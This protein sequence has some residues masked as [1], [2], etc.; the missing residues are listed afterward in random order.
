MAELKASV[1]LDLVDRISRPVQRIQRR[2]GRLAQSAGLQR[3]RRSAAAVGEGFSNV[4][5]TAGRL[6]RRLAL[7][8]GAAA[9][10]VWGFERLVSG[11]TDVGDR[12]GKLSERLGIN[13]QTLQEWQYGARLSGI[14]TQ[15]FNMALQRFSRRIGEA[16]HGT[17][18]AQV[19]V[20]YL[21]VSLRDAE[22]NIRSTEELLPEF[23]DALAGVENEQTRLALAMKLFDSEGVAMLQMLNGGSEALREFAR[24]AHRSGVVLTD[25]LIAQ[26]EDYTDSMTNFRQSLFGIRVAIVSRVIPAVTDWI[27]RMTELL[28]T[29]REALSKR[30]TEGLKR[31]WEGLKS[32]GEMLV[33]TKDLLGGWGRVAMLVG[34]VLLAPLVAPVF[35]LAAAIL[36]MGAALLAIGAPAAIAIGAIVAI[37]GAVY[38][39]YRYWDNIAG[40]FSERFD[41]VTRA[42]EQDLVL[43][44]LTTLREFNPVLLVYEAVN[45]IIRYLTGVDL[46][47][48][49]GRSVER[50]IEGAVAGLVRAQEAIAPFARRLIHGIVEVLSPTA[51]AEAGREFIGGLWRGITE[52][53]EAMTRWLTERVRSLVDW[54]PDWVQDRLGLEGIGTPQMGAPALEGDGAAAVGP[55]EARVGGELRITIDSEGRP[56]VRELRREGDMDIGVDLGV[57]VMP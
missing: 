47:A 56:R 38:L 7:A 53:F 49:I 19:A 16:A 32:V 55:G 31:F 24:E 50:L 17:G 51:L 1:I 34:A 13:A 10:A 21:G 26:A 29:N 12:I 48:V 20:R 28:R 14:N 37:A 3:L 39:L 25:E 2:F 8:G 22:G 9:G 11:V 43:G 40:W 36:Q 15:T 33:W 41:R 18:E 46:G 44:V 52:R 57:G 30:I 27:E 5:S 35:M 6:T 23:A 45:G 42:F 54:M 4:L